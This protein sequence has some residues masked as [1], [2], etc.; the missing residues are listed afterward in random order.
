MFASEFLFCLSLR[1]VS[2]GNS[3]CVSFR[4]MNLM[5]ILREWF[6]NLII[7]NAARLVSPS[8]FSEVQSSRG[9]PVCVPGLRDSVEELKNNPLT[10]RPL[11]SQTPGTSSRALSPDPQTILQPHTVQQPLPAVLDLDAGLCIS[12]SCLI[13]MDND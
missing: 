5:C 10:T 2:S 6:L 3:Y 11:P 4:L 13:M 8:G 9:F 12:C 1:L 7:L